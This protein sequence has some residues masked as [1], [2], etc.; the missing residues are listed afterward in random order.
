[1]EIEDV[2]DSYELKGRQVNA[3]I[4]KKYKET[5]LEQDMKGQF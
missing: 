4:L 5:V 3:D 1:M 2:Q